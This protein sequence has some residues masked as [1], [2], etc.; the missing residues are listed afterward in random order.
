MQIEGIGC[1]RPDDQLSTV[2][3]GFMG[4]SKVIVEDVLR[5]VGVPLFVL[6]DVALHQSQIDVF[7]CCFVF[8]V[9]LACQRTG[10]QG[11]HNQH[12]HHYEAGYG[13]VELTS[14]NEK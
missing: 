13:F 5:E 8:F 2:F 14:V 10:E 9:L 11:Q 4:E 3:N 7:D 1:L 6:R 12:D